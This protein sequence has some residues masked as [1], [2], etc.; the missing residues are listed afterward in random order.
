MTEFHVDVRDQHRYSPDACRRGDSCRT[1]GLVALGVLVQLTSNT[2]GLDE[3]VR[4]FVREVVRE[5]LA[6]RAE[7]SSD[8]DR[9][10]ATA[11]AAELAGVAEGTIRRWV[12]EGRVPGHR[13]GRVLRVRA[14]D[15]HRLLASGVSRSGPSMNLSGLSPEQLA[16]RHF[17]LLAG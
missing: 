7:T 9:Y 12:R 15:V 10:L 2:S 13:A 11:D 8:R 3:T 1:R 5:E 14:S 16:R 17:G 4:A 6:A